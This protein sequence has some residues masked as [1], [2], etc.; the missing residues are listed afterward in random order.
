MA[1]VFWDVDTQ[2]DFMFSDGKLYVTGAEQVLPQLSQLT[3][4]ARKAG[5]PIVASIDHHVMTDPELSATPDFRETF[6][7]H[8]LQGTPGHDKVDATRTLDP[9][10]V[11]DTP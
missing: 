10:Y 5:I 3:R 11:D 6:P 4:H 8:C 9:L 1:L 2:Y 7:P